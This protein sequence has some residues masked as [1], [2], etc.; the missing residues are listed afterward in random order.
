M[1]KDGT[2]SEWTYTLTVLPRGVLRGF[3]DLLRGD[4]A[5]IQRAFA[6]VA[7]LLITTS[8]FLVGKFSKTQVDTSAVPM[9][10]K[11]LGAEQ[12]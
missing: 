11:A 9:L 8:G 3:G 7:G 5:G 12:L 4:L 6:I 1:E 2:Q 10:V